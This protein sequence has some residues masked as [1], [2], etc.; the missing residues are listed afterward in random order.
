MYVQF[1]YCTHPADRQ[2][3]F[4]LVYME[5]LFAIPS[6]SP[7]DS[8]LMSSFL[9]RLALVLVAALLQAV[10]Y[11]VARSQLTNA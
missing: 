9:V 8:L 3:D 10:G 2:P 7:V 11:D 1:R 5:V 6:A 4:E